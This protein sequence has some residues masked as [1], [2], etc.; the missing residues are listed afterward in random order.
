MHSH[1][2]LKNN[3]KIFKNL[4]VCGV[5]DFNWI[6]EHCGY[7]VLRIYNLFKCFSLAGHG[8]KIPVLPALGRLK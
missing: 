2:E 4:L 5:N 1:T 6:L 8:G 7:Y 3:K